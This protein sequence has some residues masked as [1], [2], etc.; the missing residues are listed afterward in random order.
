MHF[1]LQTLFEG[2]DSD[3]VTRA[4]LSVLGSVVL[5][6]VNGVLHLLSSILSL[7]L[8]FISVGFSILSERVYSR[9]LANLVIFVIILDL[10]NTCADTIKRRLACSLGVLALGPMYSA[11]IPPL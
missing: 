11:W 10:L 2:Q 4:S 5:V 6:L 9:V 3:L 7:L 8:E 1:G